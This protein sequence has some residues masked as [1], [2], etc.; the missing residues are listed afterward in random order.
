[1]EEEDRIAEGLEIGS[2]SDEDPALES[3]LDLSELDPVELDED[4]DQFAQEDDPSLYK[5]DQQTKHVKLG[6]IYKAEPLTKKER[7]LLR[8]QALKLS[9]VAH[10]HIGNLLIM[11]L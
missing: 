8:H 11:Y 7:L 2:E 6:P 5:K 1:M 4:Y 3:S 9:K 10:F